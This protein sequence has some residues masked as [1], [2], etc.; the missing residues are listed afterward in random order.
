MNILKILF[1][2]LLFTL[3]ACAQ[4]VISQTEIRDLSVNNINSIQGKHIYRLDYMTSGELYSYA[5]YEL[6]NK[7]QYIQLLIKQGS[8]L[9]ISGTKR[10]LYPNITKCTLFPF[11]PEVDVNDC[12]NQFNQAQLDANDSD[13][14]NRILTNTDDSADSQNQKTL[15]PVFFTALFSPIIVPVAILSAPV[16][17]LEE[18]LED[19]K[20][21]EFN[22]TLGFNEQL[23]EFLD[24]LKDKSKSEKGNAGTAH[25]ESGI[26]MKMPAIAFGYIGSEVIWI[27]ENPRPTCSGG[28]ILWGM[29]C[30]FG[31]HDDDHL[32]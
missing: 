18:N 5:T 23:P 21:Q 4:H 28:Y 16:Y 27:Q 7:K 3:N 20:K 17:A 6:E 9:A 13:L 15:G 22:L 12:L 2:S 30:Q 1:I 31:K 26:I 14:L 8:V 32:R 11:H 25:I 10:A 24:T 29:K 19:S